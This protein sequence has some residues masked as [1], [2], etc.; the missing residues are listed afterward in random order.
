LAKQ[1]QSKAKR[2]ILLK[3][4][5]FKVNLVCL[6]RQLCNAL[7]LH[8]RYGVRSY[9]RQAVVVCLTLLLPLKSALQKTLNNVGLV[10]LRS[11]STPQER[12]DEDHPL[13]IFS[14]L[15]FAFSILMY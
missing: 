7:L 9:K 6:S 5:S 8:K 15:N 3:K 4:L 13:E 1:S 10:Q 12:S 11:N 2:T 14:I